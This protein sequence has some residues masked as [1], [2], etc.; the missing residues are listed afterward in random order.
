MAK[1]KVTELFKALSDY[2]HVA[3]AAWAYRD[4]PQHFKAQLDEIRERIKKAEEGGDK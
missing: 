2:F 3:E 1:D 4:C